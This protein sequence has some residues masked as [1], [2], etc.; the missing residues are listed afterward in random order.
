MNIFI[1][2]KSALNLYATIVVSAVL[3]MKSNSPVAFL[4]PFPAQ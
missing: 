3:P 4:S 2:K 1:K